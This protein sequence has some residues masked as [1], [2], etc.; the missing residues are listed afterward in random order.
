ML[1]IILF[2]IIQAYAD[3]KLTLPGK[4]RA[5]FLTL[6][7]ENLC[8]NISKLEIA[9]LLE[10]NIEALN[11]S[12]KVSQLQRSSFQW[13][14]EIHLPLD[15]ITLA[16][17]IRAPLIA[18]LQNYMTMVLLLQENLTNQ[19]T[20]Y[21][22][23][24]STVEQRMR[25]ACGANPD[26]QDIF[27]AYSTSFSTEMEALRR[28][29]TIS[30]SV[31]G[32]ISTVCNHEA[33][34][35]QTA[36]SVASD[37]A[38]VA[39]VSEFQNA[40]TLKTAQTQNQTLTE[41]ELSLFSMNPPKE[42]LPSTPSSHLDGGIV[43]FTIDRN[44]ILQTEE[45]IASRVK[46]VQNDLVQE[47]QRLTN[48]LSGLHQSVTIDLK[49]AINVHQKL[50]ADVGALLKAIDKSPEAGGE[51]DYEVP[52]IQHYLVQYRIFSD[53]LSNIMHELTRSD[54]LTEEKARYLTRN[55][56]KL[57]EVIC[58]IYEDLVEFSTLLREDNIE[59][60][61]KAR[62]EEMGNGFVTNVLN[63][64]GPNAKKP[65]SSCL[66]GAVNNVTEEKNT[67]A[68]NVLRRVRAKLEG[69]EP[70]VLRRSSVAEQVD[71]I[72]REATSLDNLSL[73]YEGWTS[74]I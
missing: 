42:I 45:A 50:M 40:I 2:I 10:H 30:K 24:H 12:Q 66:N 31:C 56:E 27:D 9:K 5:H 19:Q 1:L 13:F 53:L 34:R 61:K 49:R 69:R 41:Q 28:L 32:T 4:D 21:Q 67:F 51:T 52:E 25:W 26:L 47:N 8:A 55:L 18:D 3:K 7:I 43:D 60:Y 17:P 35:T 15:A 57:K 22:E 64:A 37:S 44:W 72:I 48:A 62:K 73:L 14:H 46:T 39:L 74:W 54:D 71:F 65:T 36:D 29:I 70:D 20:K 68:L 33:L 11:A 23:Y 63:A 38:F 58:P 16:T 6:E 59:K